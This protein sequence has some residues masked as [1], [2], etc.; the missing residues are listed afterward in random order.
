MIQSKK[1]NKKILIINVKSEI[2]NN[3]IELLKGNKKVIFNG[4]GFTIG[5]ST[6]TDTS[7]FNF[8]EL[9]SLS[10]TDDVTYSAQ[11]VS[12]SEVQDGEQ[13]IVYT[14]VWDNDQ[15]KYYFYAVDCDGT[16]LPC[17]ERGD[18]I[19]WVGSPIDTLSWDFTEYLSSNGQP[20]ISIM[21]Y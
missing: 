16:L 5:T 21:V 15:K 13:V 1:D 20:Q 10:S 18:D 19:M 3:I 14:R 2:S 9:S 8:V 7:K 4:T 6:S 17:F 11:K 12:I